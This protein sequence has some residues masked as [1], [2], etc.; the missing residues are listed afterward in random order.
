MEADPHHVLQL[1][2]T[3]GHHKQ[4][5]PWQYTVRENPRTNGASESYL[6]ELET[7]ICRPYEL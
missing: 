1:L 4:P 7:K 6:K 3:A 2:P 5:S